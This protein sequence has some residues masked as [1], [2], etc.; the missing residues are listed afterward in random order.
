[1]IDAA[2]SEKLVL[3]GDLNWHVGAEAGGF[4]EVHGSHDYESR[5]PESEMLLEFLEHVSDCGKYLVPK[6]QFAKIT[7]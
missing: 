1:L 7:Y 3:C 2:S 4:S 5:N 6:K